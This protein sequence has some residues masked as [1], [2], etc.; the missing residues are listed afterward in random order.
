[1]SGSSAWNPQVRCNSLRHL[2]FVGSE[3]SGV[4]STYSTEHDDVINNVATASER[5]TCLVQH[6]NKSLCFVFGEATDHILALLRGDRLNQGRK[7]GEGKV[8]SREVP[9]CCRIGSE[10]KIL[11]SGWYSAQKLRRCAEDIPRSDARVQRSRLKSCIWVSTFCLLYT[12]GGVLV[13]FLRV[14]SISSI[15]LRL[16]C[17]IR[18]NG[19]G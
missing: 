9:K 16:F 6:V 15:V 18:G 4:S 13:P 17:K 2:V 1:M 7:F 5:R 19:K 11:E 8:A 12:V 14:S 3:R 10:K